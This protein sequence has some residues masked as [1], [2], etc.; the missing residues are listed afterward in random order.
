MT[1]SALKEQLRAVGETMPE[2]TRIRIH[3]AISWLARAEAENDDPDARFLFLWIAF[4]AAYAREFGKEQ[5]ERDQLKTY[6]A[7]VLALDNRKQLHAVLFREFSGAI[8]TLIENKFVFEPFWRAL[9]DHDGSGRWEQQFAASRTAAMKALMGQQTDVV[10]S[11]LFDRLYVLR[12][13]LAHGG[14]TWNSK[15]NRAQVRD[16][17]HMLAAIVPVLVGLMLESPQANFGE[18]MYP[19]V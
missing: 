3:R 4:N 13:Q 7:S 18:I 12:N 10:L 11:I 15:T 1:A 9:R 5:T 19:V 16:S 2:P 6:F 17:T 8:R 14:A